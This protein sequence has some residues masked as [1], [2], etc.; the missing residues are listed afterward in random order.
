MSGIDA[1]SRQGT[2]VP[3]DVLSLR[4]SRPR[5]QQHPPRSH[6]FCPRHFLFV[7]NF[8]VLQVATICQ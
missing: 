6:P 1:P 8:I 4:K 3:V 7:L 2:Q 5:R